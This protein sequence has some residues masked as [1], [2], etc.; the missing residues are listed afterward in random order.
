M[1]P[2]AKGP[3]LVGNVVGAAFNALL[4]IDVNTGRVGALGLEPGMAI[5]EPVHVPS[6]TPGHG[7]WL[8]AVV[9]RQAAKD[10]DSELW[11]LDADDIAAPPVAR[12]LVPVP[13]RPQVH[14]CWVTA[15]QLA[16]SKRTAG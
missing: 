6:R 16:H 8:L 1:N 12:V 15:E 7:G 3:P 9:D 4:R 11:I 14:G 2:Q 10:Y 5:N 13:L